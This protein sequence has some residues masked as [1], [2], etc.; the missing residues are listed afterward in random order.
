M[1]QRGGVLEVVMLVCCLGAY[2]LH[3]GLSNK[4]KRG[5]VNQFQSSVDIS[6]D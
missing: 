5:H 3:R 4:I 1:D 2:E 6:Y